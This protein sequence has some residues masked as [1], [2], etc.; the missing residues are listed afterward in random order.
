M[1]KMQREISD[2]AFL[3]KTVSPLENAGISD[4]IHRAASNY[5]EAKNKVRKIR[6]LIN[7]G[8]YDADI[9]RYI[10]EISRNAR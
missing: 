1:Q 8:N 10:P 7:T 5:K 4:A 3:G 9:A 2:R 6:E